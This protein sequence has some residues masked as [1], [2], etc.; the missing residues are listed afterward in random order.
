MDQHSTERSFSAL[1]IAGMGA[2]L[3]CLLAVVSWFRPSLVAGRFSPT[4]PV[5]D[6]VWLFASQGVVRGYAAVFLATA[7]LWFLIARNVH[8]SAPKIF[9][10]V[11]TLV[12]VTAYLSLYWVLS[13]WLIDDAAITFAYS[14][15]LVQGHGLVLYPGYPREEAY[16]NTLWMLLLAGFR[17]LG[18]PIPVVAKVLGALIGVATIVLSTGLARRLVGP[19]NFGLLAPLLLATLLQAPYVIWSS[20]GLEHGLQGLGYLA[21]VAACVA[22][23]GDSRV[24][25]AILSALIFLRPEV[26]LVVAGVWLAFTWQEATGNG[27]GITLKVLLKHW[28]IAVVPALCLVSLVIFRMAYFGDPLATPFY[29]KAGEATLL[30]LL[31]PFGGGW[32][33]VMDWAKV[34]GMLCILPLLVFMPLQRDN[35]GMRVGFAV[36]LPQLIFVI[37]AGGDWMGCFRFMAAVVPLLAVGA[38]V[39]A[40]QLLE[41]AAGRRTV[42]MASAATAALLTFSAKALVEFRAAPTTPMSTVAEISDEFVALAGI[43]GVDE[44]SLAH[45]DAGGSSYLAKIRVVDLGGLGDRNIAKNWDNREYMREY[46]FENKRPTFIFG[47]INFAAKRSRFHELPQFGQMYVRL[48]FV[49]IPIMDSDLC[50]VRRDL[51]HEADGLKIERSADGELIRVTVMRRDGT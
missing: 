15:N 1:T 5:P 48:H 31:N 44:P 50:H 37:Y 16:S 7:I 27:G 49:G 20:S 25:T 24:P 33:Y 21:I 41:G 29:A 51:V 36:F 46:L 35:F 47:A 11:A 10:T 13:D 39:S 2:S 23:P 6:A 34:T 30:K 3:L 45:H 4:L 26:P 12:T 8:V 28:P 14:E 32:G 17:A 42:W 43:L 40:S 19:R 18:A 9:L 38:V 22:R